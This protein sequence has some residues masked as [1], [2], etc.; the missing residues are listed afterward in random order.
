MPPT[1][2]L[3]LQFSP[4]LSSEAITQMVQQGS[5]VLTTHRLLLL[6][7]VVSRSYMLLCNLPR[8]PPPALPAHPWQ[9]TH[10]SWRHAAPT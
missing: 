1:A 5:E 3:P 7:H 8:H 4:A 6:L 10:T 2:T 9:H